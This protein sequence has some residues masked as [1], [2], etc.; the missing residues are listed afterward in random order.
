MAAQPDRSAWQWLLYCGGVCLELLGL[1]FTGTVVVVFFGHVDTR[2]L[3]SLTVVGMIL[4]YS[5]WFFVRHASRRGAMGPYQR[6]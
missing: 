3:L 6:R 5:G 4:F 1:A 2:L